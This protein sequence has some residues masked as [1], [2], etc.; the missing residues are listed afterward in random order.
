MVLVR[1]L[2]KNCSNCKFSS[3]WFYNIRHYWSSKP[4]FYQC[5]PKIK[6]NC[7]SY[8]AL[9]WKLSNSWLK[10]YVSDKKKEAI[11][12]LCELIQYCYWILINRG[13]N[14]SENKCS[15]YSTSKFLSNKIFMSFSPQNCKNELCCWNNGS[16]YYCSSK[17]KR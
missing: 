9:S 5:W 10:R 8:K 13:A 11:K 16:L 14:F 15:R 17:I 2:I 6:Q 4:L 1:K 7:Q 3:C 12:H